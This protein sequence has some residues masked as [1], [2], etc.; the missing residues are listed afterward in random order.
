MLANESQVVKR[1][2]SRGVNYLELP[3]DGTKKQKQ[4]QT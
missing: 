2:Q 3:V 4:F 1:S